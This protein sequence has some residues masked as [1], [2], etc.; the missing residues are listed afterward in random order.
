LKSNSIAAKSAELGIIGF[1]NDRASILRDFATVREF[2]SAPRIECEG[3]T[4]LGMALDTTVTMMR[5]KQGEYT[6]QGI[7]NYKP[8][9]IL[10]TDGAPTDEWSAPTLRFTKEASKKGWN[11]LAV[12]YGD[13]D[14]QVLGTITKTVLKATKG[15]SFADF[16]MWISN[17]V[18]SISRSSEG[19]TVALELPPGVIQLQL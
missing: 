7:P 5:E 3:S 13:A 11:I 6:R 12:A 15:F 18:A 16:F 9:M 8:L 19:E 2:S 4:P 10:L 17:S 1:G 14:E